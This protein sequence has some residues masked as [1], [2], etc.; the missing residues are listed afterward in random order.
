MVDMNYY[1]VRQEVNRQ[2]YK[3]NVAFET[4]N[5]YF[6]AFFKEM[7]SMHNRH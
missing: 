6:T 2:Y 4:L 7:R 1:T 3:I 5:M